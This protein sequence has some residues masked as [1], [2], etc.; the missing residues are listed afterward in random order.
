VPARDAPPWQAGAVSTPAG[1][2]PRVRT[3]LAFADT[4]GSWRAR[5]GVGRL[6]YRV[7][8]GLYAVGE[9]GPESEAFV[10]ANYKMSFDRLRSC[11]DGLDA[12][13][14]VL[15]TRGINV[16]C[17]AGKGTFG[18]DELVR[19]VGATRLAEITA[20]RRLIVPQ[21]GAPGVD[22]HAVRRAAGYTVVFG[23][24]RAADI[25]A[26]LARGREATPAM[27]R[28]RFGLRDR[29]VLTPMELVGSGRWLLL[30]LLAFLLLAGLGR[31]GWSLARVG[32]TGVASAALL[33]GGYL[34]GTI[35]GPALLPLLPGRSFAAKGAW[36]G[37]ALAITVAL[38]A[39]GAGGPGG[40]PLR[41]E[42]LPWLLLLPAIASFLTMNFTGASTYTS[43]SGVLAEMRVAV[44]LQ[45]AAASVGVILW[46]A[47]LFL[48]G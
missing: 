1:P 16:W 13:L 31:D 22:A 48:R 18:T 20:H 39:G 2:V 29:L 34:C 14:L 24:V 32:S 7:E 12:W 26:F 30:A 5:W 15:D 46:L 45:I 8:P 38:L 21:L 17:A 23:P 44:P 40:A 47:L 9:P 3:K 27:R 43:L 33:L 6:T 36:L 28:V 10:S 11:L 37:L 4:L 35:L 42:L 41:W 19:R 25:P